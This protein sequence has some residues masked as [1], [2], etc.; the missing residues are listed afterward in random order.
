MYNK[1]CNNLNGLL[2][3]RKS[4]L[5]KV[6][7]SLNELKNTFKPFYLMKS[8]SFY[9]NIFICNPILQYNNSYKGLHKL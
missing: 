9:G 8:F 3:F 6:Q 1:L 7:G 4:Y 5:H 2:F